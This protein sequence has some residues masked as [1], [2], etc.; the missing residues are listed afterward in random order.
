MKKIIVPFF[1]FLMALSGCSGITYNTL[2]YKP[3]EGSDVS[4]EGINSL[5]VDWINGSVIIEQGDNNKALVNESESEYPLYYKV[6]NQKLFIE[7]AKSGTSSAIINKL[8][9]DLH[10]V[11][12]SFL[13]Y[14]YVSAV[15]ASLYLKGD[16]TIEK[17][18]FKTVNGN[19]KMDHYKASES[20]FDGVNNNIEIANI[21]YAI[22]EQKD[23]CIIQEGTSECVQPEP[24]AVEHTVNMDLV[25]CVVNMGISSK[26]GYE[27]YYSSINSFVTSDFGD[28]AS[29]KPD[30]IR[31]NLDLV[32]SSI[33]IKKVD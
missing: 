33:K 2:G 16:V 28:D 20:S 12:P 18:T 6:N 5:S 23:I 3:L 14:L 22:A 29:Y 26:V 19:I 8:N 10:I 11:V 32:N 9:K 27:Y 7:V 24:V 21:D 1:I 13:N 15:N 31:L 17:G 30:L 4:F 25:N